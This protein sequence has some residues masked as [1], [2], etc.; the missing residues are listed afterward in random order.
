[1]MMK[2]TEPLDRL[3]REAAGERTD[4]APSRRAIRAALGLK[5]AQQERREAR[6]R[7]LRT[8][9]VAAALLVV[10]SG[11]LGSDDFETSVRTF[12]K[13][14]TKV[15]TY[16]QGLRG[17]EVTTTGPESGPELSRETAED[18]LI[19][20]SATDAVPVLLN[21]WQVGQTRHL[22]LACEYRL[23]D[24]RIMT[25]DY[26]V[27]GSS[28]KSAA[29]VKAWFGGERRELIPVIV[30]IT[31][32]RAPDLTI[33]MY[34]DGLRWSVDG[35]RIRLPGRQEIIFYTGVRAD[36]VQPQLND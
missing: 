32:S 31:Q 3:L 2:K 28:D 21:G 23:W 17:A 6:A 13:G 26:P 4:P 20:K 35:W 22:S 36:G 10:L 8:A 27:G 5:L 18:L 25:S 16:R 34:V 1:M 33:P 9:F 14:D 30:G 12:M 15:T 24:G 29:A 7:V 19:A 11:P